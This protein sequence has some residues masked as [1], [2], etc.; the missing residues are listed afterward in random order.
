MRKSIL[1]ALALVSS[2]VYAQNVDVPPGYADLAKLEV[3][4]VAGDITDRPYRVIGTVN[5][6]VRKAT[7]FSKSSSEAK[8][9]RELWESA[10]KLGADAV[11]FAE[12]GDSRVTGFSWGAREARGKAIKFLTDAE[13]AAI[14]VKP[15]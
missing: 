2:P 12:Y 3:P 6:N 7:V 15:N 4:V 1:F 9:Y 8:V 14:P 10:Q 13:I 11:V 5:K